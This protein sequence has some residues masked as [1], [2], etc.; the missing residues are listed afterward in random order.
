MESIERVPVGAVRPRVTGT[1]TVIVRLVLLLGGKINC[2]QGPPIRLKEI[3]SP[4][5]TRNKNRS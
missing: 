3:D 1:S 5:T 4:V 2:V